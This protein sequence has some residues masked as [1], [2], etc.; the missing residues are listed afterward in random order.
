MK[1]FST[2]FISILLFLTLI[3]SNA[4]AKQAF[5]IPDDDKN[6]VLVFISEH[7]NK[8]QNLYT[9]DSNLIRQIEND[10]DFSKPSPR[11]TCGYDYYM[12]LL[13]DRRLINYAE[14]NFD[15]KEIVTDDGAFK[16]CPKKWKKIKP[17]L[18]PLTVRRIVFE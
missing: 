16:F 2:A 17:F 7:D 6:L 10:W 14:I 12:Y 9:D 13:Q 1:S 8:Q 4:H 3:C 11:Y 18:K 15:C 5:E